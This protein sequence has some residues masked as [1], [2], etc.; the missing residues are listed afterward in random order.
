[1]LLITRGIVA[2]AL[3]KMTFAMT[4]GL[5]SNLAAWGQTIPSDAKANDPSCTVT[6]AQFAGWFESGTPSLNGVVRPAD[7]LNFSD[8]PNCPFYQWAEQMFLALTSPATDCGGTTHIFD[9]PAFF[10]VSSPDASGNRVFITHT[11]SASGGVNRL[12]NLRSAQ[13]GGRGLPVIFDKAGRMLEVELRAD[14]PRRESAGLRL[15]RHK[16]RGPERHA[17]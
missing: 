10:D 13:V 8:Q 14:G 9:T 17:R 2:P 6:A 15:G 3:L 5:L 12:L 16:R 7:S 1:M 4:L 11:C